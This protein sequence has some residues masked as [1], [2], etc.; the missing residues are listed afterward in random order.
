MNFFIPCYLIAGL[1]CIA[2]AFRFRGERGLLTIVMLQFIVS[3]YALNNIIPV[4]ERAVPWFAVLLVILGIGLLGY[5]FHGAMPKPVRWFLA[6]VLGLSFATFLYLAIS[7]IPLY[8]ISIPGLLALGLSIHAFIPALFCLHII[9]L[10]R[11]NFSSA[12]SWIA[13]TAGIVLPVVALAG[14]TFLFNARLERV[15]RV[16]RIEK[17]EQRTDLPAWVVAARDL[18][19]DWLTRCVLQSE[20]AYSKLP[21]PFTFNFTPSREGEARLFDP[22]VS[23]AMAFGPTQAMSAEERWALL[24]TRRKSRHL[25]EERLWSGDLLATD[26]VNTRVRIWPEQRMAYTEKTITV[27]N[28]ARYAWRNQEAIYTFHLPEGAVVTSLSLWIG[29]REE[30]GVLTTR[31]K[32]DTAYKTIVGREMRDPSLVRWQE[33]N[34]VSVRVFPVEGGKTRQ[35]RI[36]YT[37][38]LQLQ[39][40]EQRYTNAWIEGPHTDHADEDVTL[41]FMTP[42]SFPHIPRGFEQNGNTWTASRRYRADWSFSLLNK[43]GVQGAFTFNGHTYTIADIPVDRVPTDIR[44]IYLDVNKSWSKNEC[45]A[46]LHMAGQR[47]VFVWSGASMQPLTFATM[48]NVLPLTQNFSLFPVFR[49]PDPAHALLVTKGSSYSPTLAELD[50]HPFGKDLR[51][52]LA[53][54]SLP[55]ICLMNIGQELSPYLQTLREKRAFRYE[56][57]GTL[58][59]KVLLDTKT[60]APDLETNGR[61]TLSSAGITITKTPADSIT[62]A[63]TAPDHLM[64]LFA[65]NHI[66][67]QASRGASPDSLAA[68]AQEAYVVSPLTSLVVLEKQADY[69]RFGIK[70]EGNSL[71]NATLKNNGAA[72]EPHEWMLIILVAG[73]FIYL[74]YKKRWNTA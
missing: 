62:P 43:R 27:H 30:K 56:H 14:F 51:A 73:A 69:D 21:N 66:L 11:R 54:T 4:F 74:I 2:Y 42:P 22:L 45:R 33:G 16:F 39:H 9:R 23:F 71:R 28:Y 72:P 12:A 18:P 10:A 48:D 19:D 61:I 70:D 24:D 8:P 17:A 25:A 41:E 35:F 15:N 13:F 20:V 68:L 49:I 64:R 36:G 50:D 38:P 57:G 53:D 7:L 55:K 34:T 46:I 3:C 5:R 60:F 52:W 37:A 63:N 26:Y 47:S 58:Q 32:A 59:L 67:R 40:G 6:S 1:S 65:Y 29:D 31:G 44:S